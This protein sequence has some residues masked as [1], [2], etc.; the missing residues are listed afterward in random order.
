MKNLFNVPGLILAIILTFSCEEKPVPPSLSTTAVTEISTTTAVFGGKITADGG[1]TII[2]RGV[3][4]D[5][6]DD[7]TIENN[8]TSEN[9]ELLSFTSNITQL[10][11]N[12]SYYV[13]AYATNSAGTG[14]GESVS[15]KTL[16]DKPASNGQNASNV[17]INSAT[18]AGSVNPNFLS[19]TVTFEYGVT[20]S[21]GSSAT[22]L[23][24][25]LSGDKV[26]NVTVKADLS[27]LTP[28]TTYHFRIKAENSLGT[29]YGS[30]LA[31]TTLGQVPAVNA[32]AASNLQVRTATIN[33]SINPNYLPTT[34]TFEWGTTT[35]YGNTTAIQDA[36]NENSVVS[37][38]ESLLGLTPGTIYHY[39][40]NATNELGTTQSNDMTFRTLG[41]VPF[42]LVKSAINTQYNSATLSG[43]INPNYL[44]TTVEFEYGTTSA[45]GNTLSISH[46][47]FTGK[48]TINVSADL[49][50]L[51]QGT[52]YHFRI[53]ASNELGTIN[54]ADYTF[55]TLAPI[56]DIDGN[57]YNIKTIGNQIWMTEN[58]K[59][60]KYSD[61]TSISHGLYYPDNDISK[62]N[63]YGILYD[64]AAAIKQ[65]PK[66]DTI[67]LDL[68][69]LRVQ[70]V[71]PTNWH[72]PNEDEWM[73]LIDLFGGK[74]VAGLKLKIANPG[75]WLE[76]LNIQ[77]PLS[78]FNAIPAGQFYG[79][80]S[81]V[82]GDA[83]IYWTTN[84]WCMGGTIMGRNVSMLYFNPNVVITATSSNNQPGSIGLSVRCIR[85]Y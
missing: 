5:T 20:T 67:M 7:P 85:D 18:L 17:T 38:S 10:S 24:S 76:P 59:T 22:A 75:Y 58:L 44:S 69:G 79:K 30:D 6:S 2:S 78:G 26:E 45:Y 23:E 11:P 63:K 60:T 40:I 64:W 68:Q 65:S 84:Q 4:W 32:Q 25:P 83:A 50:G 42:A 48:D 54:S 81:T 8:K 19:T 14:Y 82:S 43:Q 34:V 16:G 56:T 55:T 39:R 1:A 71:C 80:W 61:G 70:G 49:S 74:E 21:Y 53:K 31:F 35:G 3:C 46:G 62:V 37:V 28:G 51:N 9:S 57:T 12:T 66:Y 77:E 47:P 29:T 15:F 36:G 73:E 27:E 13:R 52:L 33:G 72:L 41:D